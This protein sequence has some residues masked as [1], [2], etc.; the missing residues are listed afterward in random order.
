MF[1]PGHR[2][3]VSDILACTQ[4]LTLVG[5]SS[6]KQQIEQQIVQQ[7]DRYTVTG[8]ESTIDAHHTIKQ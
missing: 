6:L 7:I 3:A 2:L 8:E 4:N 1:T 5:V